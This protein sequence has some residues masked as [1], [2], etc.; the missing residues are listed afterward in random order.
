MALE[1]IRFDIQDFIKTPE[2]QA[3]VLEAALEDWRSRSNRNVS[4]PT[5]R[6]AQRRNGIGPDE[7]RKPATGV[8][9][10]L[11]LAGAGRLASVESIFCKTVL[12]ASHAPRPK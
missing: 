7:R 4:S 9:V 8:D 12:G 5:V 6:E 1:T 11:I 3:G 10:A 2:Q